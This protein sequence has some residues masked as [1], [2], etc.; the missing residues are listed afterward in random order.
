MASAVGTSP[1]NDGRITRLPPWAG[2]SADRA[3][4]GVDF[5]T[6]TLSAVVDAGEH[7]AHLS[8]ACRER[9]PGRVGFDHAEVCE[10]SSGSGSGSGS[11]SATTT[12]KERRRR[13]NV[14]TATATSMTVMPTTLVDTR[15]G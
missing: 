6:W 7:H 13:R 1:S 5:G 15:F 3:G 8:P 2:P 14:P 11:G 9:V 4:C 12:G 10:L